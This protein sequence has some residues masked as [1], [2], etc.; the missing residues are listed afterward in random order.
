MIFDTTNDY[1]VNASQV[2]K[3]MQVND[4][5]VFKLMFLPAVQG[6]INRHH[7]ANKGSFSRQISDDKATFTVTRTA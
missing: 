7:K 5:A 3:Q 2:F 4:K 1:S 6:V